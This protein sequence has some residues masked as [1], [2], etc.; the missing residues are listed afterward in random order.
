MSKKNTDVSVPSKAGIVAGQGGVFRRTEHIKNSAD[1]K[2]LFKCGKRVSISGAKLFYA[3][4]AL[5]TNRIGFSLSRGYGN[6]VQR[7][8]SKRYSRE[9]YRLLKARLNTGYDLVLLV[10]PGNDSFNMRCAQFLMLCR[11][12]GLM[13]P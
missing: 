9:V 8:R 3:A 7:N 2:R 10:Y 11:K 12:A 13:R 1:F 4:N 6:A 5:G